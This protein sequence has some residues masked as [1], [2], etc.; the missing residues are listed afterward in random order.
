MN[1]DEQQIRDLVATWMA[2]TRSGDVDTVLGLM[3]DDVV[4]LVPGKPPMR[5]AEFAAAARAQ[6]QPGA[7]VIDGNSD[8][9]EIRV[10]GDWA[11]LWSKLEVRVTPQGGEKGMKRA[12]HT[13]TVLR[14]V[15]GKW[16]LARDAN[17][18]VADAS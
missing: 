9:Q 2:A 10:S 5:K 14:K 15:G 4:F 1:S 13:L 8:I 12:G 7:P 11:F 16:L 6:A 18:L 17:L 3:T